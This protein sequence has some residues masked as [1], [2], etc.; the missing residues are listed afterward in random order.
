LPCV[1]CSTDSANRLHDAAFDHGLIAFDDNLLLMLAI[2]L[3]SFL[4][5][6]AVVAQ[7]EA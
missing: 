3:K 6:E 7:F 1:R 2:R 5:Q 4:P